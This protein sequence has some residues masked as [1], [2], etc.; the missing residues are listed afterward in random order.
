MFC[1][2]SYR[3]KFPAQ[4]HSRK[5]IG[6]CQPLQ[7]RLISPLHVQSVQKNESVHLSEKETPSHNQSPFRF[8]RA[9]YPETKRE[10]RVATDCLAVFSWATRDDETAA[11]SSILS[12]FT[13]SRGATLY[14]PS[15][16]CPSTVSVAAADDISVFF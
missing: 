4:I 15:P 9:L 5:H 6:L 14:I 11:L 2:S 7:E 3:H 10:E 8:R 12:C 13:F 1:A 16:P